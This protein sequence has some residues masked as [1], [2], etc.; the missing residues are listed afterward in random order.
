MISLIVLISLIVSSIVRAQVG[1]PPGQ[2]VEKTPATPNGICKFVPAGYYP[3]KTNVI[4]SPIKKWVGIHANFDFTDMLA[5]V[6]DDYIYSSRDSG[7][8]WTPYTKSNKGLKYGDITASNDMQ[9][10]VACANLQGIVFSNNSGT[11]WG[12]L[13]GASTYPNNRWIG[14]SGN[15]KLDKMIFSSYKDYLYITV[16]NGTTLTP[17]TGSGK[18]GWASLYVSEDFQK[19]IAADNDAKLLRVSLNGGQSFTTITSSTLPNAEFWGVTASN[20]LQY[21]SATISNK[22]VVSINSGKTWSTDTAIGSS[23]AYYGI[24]MNSIGSQFAVAALN[25]KIKQNLNGTWVTNGKLTGPAPTGGADDYAPCPIGTTSISG[26]TTCTVSAVICN[27]GLYVYAGYCHPCP[28]GRYKTTK[29]NDPTC[30]ECNPGSYQPNVAST[31]CSWCPLNTFNIAAGSI[32]CTNC[33]IGYVSNVGSTKC[34]VPVPSASPTLPLP[35]AIPTFSP[36][37][38][39]QTPSPSSVP[40]TNAPSSKP[41]PSQQPTSP[42][43]VTSN[44]PHGSIEFSGTC[45]ECDAGSIPASNKKQCSVCNEGKYSVKGGGDCINCASGEYSAAGS[46]VCLNCDSGTSSLAGGKCSICPPG[47]SS[48]SGGSCANCSI[49]TYAE[50][51]GSS[52]CTACP[53]GKTTNSLLGQTKCTAP[54]TNNKTPTTNKSSS[55]GGGS[56]AGISVAVI[57]CVVIIGIYYYRKEIVL[58]KPEKDRTEIEHWL[59]NPYAKLIE[60]YESQNGGSNFSVTGGNGSNGNSQVSEDENPMH[61]ITN[62]SSNPPVNMQSMQGL[63]DGTE[64]GK[65]SVEMSNISLRSTTPMKTESTTVTTEDGVETKTEEPTNE[66]HSTRAMTRASVMYQSGANPLSKSPGPRSPVPRA[67]APRAAAPRA[68]APRGSV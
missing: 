30:I 1:C 44:C 45:E 21:I 48:V 53:S 35:T 38:V 2:Y 43:S 10:I 7:G 40:T 55:S 47:T 58:P 36:T 13:P 6:E 39:N 50:N 5:T 65:S 27:P 32:A 23:G 57:F 68:A 29:A 67:A 56:S 60:F 22:I 34:A 59:V 41:I 18:N 9:K 61:T 4:D 3:I 11:N 12:Q 64:T 25:G 24:T 52:S 42:P 8:T 14:V 16:D 46:P 28:A 20:N 17:L 62:I 15:N 63:E 31:K 51:A 66:K 33:D 26:A 37:V 19:V 54:S 49:N